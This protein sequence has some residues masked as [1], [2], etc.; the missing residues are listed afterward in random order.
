MKGGPMI[1]SPPPAGPAETRVTWELSS[2]PD[3]PVEVGHG[4][5]ERVVGNQLL[6]REVNERI[7]ELTAAWIGKDPQVLICE[8]CDQGCA[9]GIEV[10]VAEFDAVRAGKARFL[11]ALGHQRPGVEQVVKRNNRFA[12]VEDDRNRRQVPSSGA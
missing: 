4:R 11:V 7:I 9:E 5:G 1:F 2:F 3:R 12:V 8:C 6:F 10:T